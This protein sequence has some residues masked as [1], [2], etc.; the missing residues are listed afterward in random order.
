M[1]GEQELVHIFNVPADEAAKQALMGFLDELENRIK[2]F[3]GISLMGKNVNSTAEFKASSQ[4]MAAAMERIMAL[5]K[6]LQAL[7]DTGSAK[8]KVRT[9]EE[10]K[11]SLQLRAET[12]QRTDTIK[13]E[14]D[15]YKQLSLAYNQAAAEAKKL[16]AIAL[17]SGLKA[18]ATAADAASRSAKGLSDALKLIDRS[19]GDNRRN[20]GNYKE[21]LEQLERELYGVRIGIAKMAGLGDSAGAEMDVMKMHAAALVG[22]IHR[23]KAESAEAGEAIGEKGMVGGL[24]E[25]G[26]E[27][28]V[29]A[30]MFIGIYQAF[31]FFKDGVKEFLHAQQEA[32]K[33]NNILRNLGRQDVFERLIKGAEEM[34]NEFKTIKSE[35]LVGVFQKLITYGKLSE[36]QI[37]ELT[38][39]I[40][41]FA[42]QSGLSL[43][44][45]ASVIIKALE[46]QARG[47]KEYG[48]N[49][50]KGAT[51]AENFGKVMQD[52]A[53][54]VEGAAKAFGETTAGEIKKT[55][56][57]IDEVK[58]KIGE[59]LLPVIKGFFGFISQSVQGLVL[60][61]GKISDF[62]DRFKIIAKQG[63]FGIQAK[64][65]LDSIHEEQEKQK[66]VNERFAL[67]YLEGD[68]FA[69]ANKTQQQAF[70]K[71][72]ENDVNR[73]NDMLQY[74]IS[75]HHNS[76]VKLYSTMLDR[77]QL[78]QK[79]AKE[80]FEGDK[81]LGFGQDDSD[82][83]IKALEDYAA[84]FKEIL[85]EISG[86]GS[87]AKNEA[88]NGLDP[89]LN[90]LRK[91]FDGYNKFFDVE[92]LVKELN[93]A[94]EE[95]QKFFVQIRDLR[96]K[97]LK[98]NDNKLKAK[99]ITQ[100]QAASQRKI[101]EEKSQQDFA[102]L[103]ATYQGVKL[104]ITEKYR[105]KAI[106]GSKEES[107]ADFKEQVKSID[108]QSAVLEKQ[109]EQ[110][111]K[112][113]AARANI[114]ARDP[115]SP[116][117]DLAKQKKVNAEEMNLEI[118]GLNK[119][120]NHG[121]VSEIEYQDQ[122]EAIKKKYRDKNQAAEITAVQK[123][124]GK[125]AEYTREGEKLAGGILDNNVTK[126]KNALQQQEDQQQ[127]AYESE[128]S[129]VNASTLNQTEKAAEL[130]VMEKQRQTQKEANDRKQRQ[131]DQ[132]KARFD[133]AKAIMEIILHTAVAIAAD[134]ATPWK[135]VV[136]AAVGGA[137]LAIAAAQQIPQY[138]VGTDFHPGGPM[139]VH[140]GELRVD[141]DGTITPT[142]NKATLTFGE[143]GTKIIA[144]DEVSRM[145]LDNVMAGTGR[146]VQQNSNQETLNEI[147]GLR[148]DL[149]Q[150]SQAQIN[151]FRKQKPSETH[152]HIDTGFWAHIK[153][154]C[155]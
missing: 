122:L 36:N 133:K 138:E 109:A 21:A 151:A 6:E 142:P 71:K 91:I 126:K 51:V 102:A 31:E 44:E 98:D 12:K 16:Q 68:K 137:E 116:D 76:E 131:M 40:V 47:L 70:L 86:Y 15:A 77:Y 32:S 123:T 111:F 108:R 85:N 42:A 63:Y 115:K 82:K 153:N 5:E 117:S 3:S 57:E 17:T 103:N 119:L 147:R 145:L 46:G 62:F 7:R 121:L 84:R 134:L 2:G 112:D 100:A 152:I 94:E 140:P 125:I 27:L 28:L 69:Q 55:E 54:R 67:F 4:E 79:K 37:K 83:K 136:D 10:I 8:N 24:K 60:M 149:K 104:A 148:E 143:R 20:V 118:F 132:E 11:A 73:T 99:D 38:P 120:H 35:D 114:N 1:P 105:R 52:L 80:I 150:S 13:A 22:E 95:Y 50:Q 135:I 53:P 43:D 61:G 19:V 107:D 154:S 9:D 110:F 113:K 81:T 23:L 34:A 129:R 72:Y 18:D 139:V 25:F 128:T 124:V 64:D 59:E 96:E 30:T 90:E 88:I 56:V 74:A 14:G 101:I 78:V 89:L 146:F 48:I 93:T 58:K 127:K 141:P 130:T 75:K 97:D 65:M 39:V 41:N 106:Q 155:N 49:I 87:K 45:S 144:A 33:L 66:E 92:P 26:K 29:Q